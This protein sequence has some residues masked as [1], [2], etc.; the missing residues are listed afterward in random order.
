M[1]EGAAAGPV[2]LWRDWHFLLALLMAPIAWL[3]ILQAGVPVIAPAWVAALPWHFAWLAL[4]APAVEE[5]VFRGAMQPGLLRIITGTQCRLASFSAAQKAQVLANVAT[6]LLFSAMHLLAHPPVWAAA[7][8][9]PS[10]VF[11]YFRDRH[12]SLLSPIVL[13]AVY[14]AGYFLLFGPAK[15][16]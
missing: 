13:H 6:S 2:R 8:F 7:V 5:L 12:N 11:G 16:L 9:V 15:N 4:V 10:L 1:N 14:N 3:S